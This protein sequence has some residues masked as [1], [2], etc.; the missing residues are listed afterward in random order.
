M[1]HEM[2]DE[3]QHSVRS[4]G[5]KP[6]RPVS[7]Q[8]GDSGWSRAANGSLLSP[9]GAVI[10]FFVALGIFVISAG[11]GRFLLGTTAD[12]ASN[13]RVEDDGLT[14]AAEEAAQLL[15]EPTSKTWECAE[16][17]RPVLKGVDVVSYF[18]LEQH[19]AA[20]YGTEEHESVF[21]GY[22]FL[23]VSAEN[24]A[25]FEVITVP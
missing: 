11:T 12:Q 23:F 14:S 9:G 20:M 15:I 22:K 21:G 5:A 2:V 16:S 6:N 3:S 25:L 24:K 4:D 7:L 19:E 8:K 13:L 10:T 18:S 1:V 17:S